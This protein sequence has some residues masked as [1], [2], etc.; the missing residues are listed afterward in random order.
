LHQ[1]YLKSQQEKQHQ[2]KQQHPV[3][4]IQYDYDQPE[5]FYCN[6]HR[7]FTSIHACNAHLQARKH[8]TWQSKNN[9]NDIHDHHQDHFGVPSSFCHYGSESIRKH[10]LKQQDRLEQRQRHSD[11][12]SSS[13]SIRSQR[14]NEEE[15]ATPLVRTAVDY[16]VAMLQ[17]RRPYMEDMYI[18]EVQS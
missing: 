15:N 9:K 10:M 6:C 3:N 11:D 7:S 12:K 16:G 13:S 18:V 4:L 5:T 14:E 17:G 1:T 8:Y 2:Q